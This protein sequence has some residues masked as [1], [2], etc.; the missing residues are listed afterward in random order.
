MEERR[1]PYLVLQ[2]AR[3]FGANRYKV[4]TIKFSHGYHKLPI[5][6][7]ER[8]SK[9][10]L[11]QVLKVNFKDLSPAFV[12]YDTIYGTRQTGIEKYPLPEGELI[13]LI[14]QDEAFLQIYTTIRRYTP[15]KWTYYKSQ[16]GELFN[17]KLVPPEKS[18]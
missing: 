5:G 9:S 16:E 7:F 1:E 15:E 4:N 8:G 12:G 14:L 11:L 3:K 10:R 2:R 6:I 18:V 17:I 13:L